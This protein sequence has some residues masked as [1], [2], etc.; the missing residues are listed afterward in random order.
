MKP[1]PSAPPTA[2]PMDPDQAQQARPGYGV[3]SQDPRA[4]AQTPLRPEEAEREAKS[5]LAG[6]G[7]IAGAATGALIGVAV[8]GPVGVVVGGT[9]GAVAGVL[10]SAAAG[11]VVKPKAPD[12]ATDTP[13]AP[14]PRHTD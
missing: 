3:P 5:V 1:A 8:A 7:A 11:G 2:E 6:G 4:G 9:V 13:S 10:G 14:G 12:N